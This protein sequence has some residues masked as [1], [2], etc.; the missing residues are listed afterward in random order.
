M[1]HYQLIEH[2]ADVGIEVHATTLK[3]LYIQ[4]ALAIRKV[5]FDQTRSAVVEY[6]SIHVHGEGREELFIN[7]LNEILYQVHV[8]HFY[9][10]CFRIDQHDESQLQATL[11][12]SDFLINGEIVQRQVKE[13]TYQQFE[14][15][16]FEARNCWFARFCID[17]SSLNH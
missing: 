6:K 15:N 1:D 8:H 5:V 13:I 12:G 11:G 4:A 14:L 3:G 7:W 10:E 16:F 2:A 9:P 17:L